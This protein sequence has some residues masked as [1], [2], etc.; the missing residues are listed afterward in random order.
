MAY[1]PFVRGLVA[2]IN[3][4]PC[5]KT[6]MSPSDVCVCMKQTGKAGDWCKV[7]VTSKAT[8]ARYG[9][10]PVA[11]TSKPCRGIPKPK[12][13]EGWPY[14]HCHGCPCHSCHWHLSWCNS[15][16][17]WWCIDW[18][19]PT[20]TGPVVVHPHTGFWWTATGPLLELI[21]L[22]L[23]VQLQLV[24]VQSGCSFFQF[25]QLDF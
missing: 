3:V 12:V 15:S 8:T 25:L 7:C 23:Q 24:A 18:S 20:S 14:R 22:Q 1:E 17:G 16:H 11:A 5:A 6:E 10:C 9:N 13:L 2:V 21:G 19:W 4:H